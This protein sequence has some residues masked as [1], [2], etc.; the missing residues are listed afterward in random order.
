MLD[1]N[2]TILLPTRG[3]TEGLRHRLK[4][5]DLMAIL[6][7]EGRGAALS[8][9]ELPLSITTPE[10]RATWMMLTRGPLCKELTIL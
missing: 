10:V 5:G 3:V 1:L 7:A 4:D 8:A 2:R 6:S 9:E